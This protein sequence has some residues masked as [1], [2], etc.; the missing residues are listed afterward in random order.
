MPVDEGRSAE[1]A[2]TSGRVPAQAASGQRPGG[3]IHDIGYQRY[4]G[5]RLGRGYAVRSLYVHSLRL[6]FGLGRSAKAKIFPWMVA[7]FAFTVAVVAVAVRAQSETPLLGYREFTD[8]ISIPTLLFLAI[9]APELVSREMRAKVLPLYFSR[10]L[11][12]GDYALAKLGAMVSAV[13]L[14]LAGPQL[15]M[16]IGGVFSRKDGFSGVLDECMDFLGGVSYAAIVAV[17]FSTLAILVASL[18][19]RRAV[20][21]ASIAAVY[22][23]TAPVA[24]VLGVLGGASA[25]IAPIIN[26]VS[27]VE[28]LEAWVYQANTG[29][30]I[31]NHG[32]L[33]PI[34]AVALVTVYVTLLLARYR[35][36]AA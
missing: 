20:A 17:V 36:V 5:P 32:Y 11:R 22:L 9:V 19:G 18:S 34:A 31:G 23:V 29:V 21:A 2:G 25:T 15:L 10:P 1:M 30:D 8:V 27:L 28:G 33:Y 6:A 12:R 14:L 35:K 24:V 13:W 4:T 7:G 3:V 26:P 16:L